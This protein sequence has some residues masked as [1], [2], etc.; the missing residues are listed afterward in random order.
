MKTPQEVEEE[1]QKILK[2][3]DCGLEILYKRKDK[4][5]E[6]KMQVKRLETKK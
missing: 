5:F 3:N 4:K 1:I 6:F 2:E